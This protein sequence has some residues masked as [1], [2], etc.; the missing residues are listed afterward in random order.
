MFSYKIISIFRYINYTVYIR[1]YRCG[2]V[3]LCTKCHQRCVAMPP[4]HLIVIWW[5][6]A[7]RILLASKKLKPPPADVWYNKYQFSI[8][9]SCTKF[10]AL[11]CLGICA[12]YTLGWLWNIGYVF[13][14][15]LNRSWTFFSCGARA[16]KLM[17]WTLRNMYLFIL[18]R[19]YIV[20]VER[21]GKHKFIYLC[22]Y[23]CDET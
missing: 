5:V 17:H 9:I 16:N 10:A 8:R 19:E 15:H 12:L 6:F 1:P 2:V 23:S 21:R 4:A 14:A 7:V 13:R 18:L 3:A 20:D 22:V 11:F